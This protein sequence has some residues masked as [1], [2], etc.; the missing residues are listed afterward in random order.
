MGK[1]HVRIC[2]RSLLCSRSPQI[3]CL[4]LPGCPMSGLAHGRAAAAAA[5]VAI[6]HPIKV[7]TFF[8]FARKASLI[9]AHGNLG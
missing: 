1:I 8:S 9:L 4:G 3:L 7:L 5:L 2:K 6:K